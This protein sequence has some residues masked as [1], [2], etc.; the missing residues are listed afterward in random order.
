M[1]SIFI[2]F[3]Y[4]GLNITSD[5]LNNQGAYSSKSKHFKKYL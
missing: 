2:G 1:R 3:E 4:Q 5:I